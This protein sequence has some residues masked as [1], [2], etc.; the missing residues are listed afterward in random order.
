[1]TRLS[2]KVIHK[3][4]IFQVIF[5]LSA[6]R[7]RIAEAL[8]LEEL[9]LVASALPVDDAFDLESCRINDNV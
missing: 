4:G 2:A 6:R 3:P 1:M 9:R 8:A 7:S 5:E